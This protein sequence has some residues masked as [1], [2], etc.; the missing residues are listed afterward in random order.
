MGCCDIILALLKELPVIGGVIGG[1][2][3]LYKWRYDVRMKRIERFYE[4]VNSIR[5]KPNLTEMIYLLD[6]DSKKWY[7]VD[8]SDTDE[9]APWLDELLLHYCHVLN[10]RNNGFIDVSGFRSLAYEIDRSLC[11][12]QLQD[13]LFNLRMYAKKKGQEFGGKKL[14][15]PFET[16]VR[17]GLNSGY[18]S[19]RVFEEDYPES[20]MNDYYI[21]WI[22]DE[23]V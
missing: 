5:E 14:S 7:S 16:L 22:K 2:I 15:F 19:K 10:L 4:L 13:Y 1:C 11:N 12:K 6:D 17:Y 18:L 9:R 3:A 8:F 20:W 21:Q 23:N